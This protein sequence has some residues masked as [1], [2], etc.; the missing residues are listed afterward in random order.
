M[1]RGRLWKEMEDTAREAETARPKGEDP[2]QVLQFLTTEHF[3]LQTARGATVADSSGR[4][5]LFLNTVSSVVVALAFIGQVSRIGEAFFVW[6]FVL[7]PTLFFL[8]LAT[9]ARVLE[10]AIEDTLYARGINRI[11]HYYVEIAPTARDY[12]LL[13]THDDM[14]GILQ[15]MAVRSSP[16][17][18][19]LTTAGMV[20]VINSVIA[21]TFAGLLARAAFRLPILVC[22]G[23]G[24]AGFG[25]CLGLL[26]RYQGKQWRQAEQEPPV[27]FPTP[28]PKQA[29]KHDS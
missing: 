23:A 29:G 7:L 24:I 25:L 9:F 14:A 18:M 3:T 20:A 6:A 10:S 13:S 22:A 27:L 5:S 12:F 17:Q 11:R 19:F 26:Q 8:G 4:A 1:G 28:N 21:G 2:Q 15:N 16:W